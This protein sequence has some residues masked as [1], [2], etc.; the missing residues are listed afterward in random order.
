VTHGAAERSIQ[1]GATTQDG[2]FELSVANAGEPIP[3]KAL[4]R[5][6]Q[7]FDR[8]A[9][10]GSQQG[11]SLHLRNR[12]C[13]RRFAGRD[14]IQVPDAASGKQNGHRQRGAKKHSAS[15]FT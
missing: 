2:K 11:L 14:A 5:L 9:E 10:Q 8:V 4:E 7:P 3:S 15:F 12:A 1:V 13:P 6:F